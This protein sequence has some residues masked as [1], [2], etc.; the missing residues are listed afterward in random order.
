MPTGDVEV[1]PEYPLPS[2]LELHGLH[3]CNAV[4]EARQFRRLW[5][6][7]SWNFTPEQPFN[8]LVGR[9]TAAKAQAVAAAAKRLADTTA[10]LHQLWCPGF[11]FDSRPVDARAA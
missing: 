9:R 7:S 1:W 4:E 2:F 10:R 8:E 3:R 11:I 5:V 6:Q